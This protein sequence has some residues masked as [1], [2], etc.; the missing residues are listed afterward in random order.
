MENLEKLVNVF[1]EVF[2]VETSVITDDFGKDTV[3]TW[4]SVHQLN[5]IALLEETFDLLLEPEDIMACTSF[6]KAKEILR[7]ND[8]EI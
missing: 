2:N 6:A 3:E 4:D 7:R 5:I 8:V 1:V